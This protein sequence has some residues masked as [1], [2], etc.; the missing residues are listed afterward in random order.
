[1]PK[2]E[3]YATI[4]GTSYMGTYEANTKKEAAEMM[5]KNRHT[6]CL[7]TNLIVEGI[8]DAKAKVLRVEKV[9]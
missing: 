3:V 9:E 5:L 1:M 6:E 2:Y 4:T 8:D 7:L